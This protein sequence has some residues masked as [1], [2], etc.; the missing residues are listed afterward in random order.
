VTWDHN[1]PSTEERS[2]GFNGESGIVEETAG[3]FW[4]AELLNCFCM[5]TES[6][7]TG[8]L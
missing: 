7:H 1:P 6:E 2:G 8:W 3:L 5:E 4:V